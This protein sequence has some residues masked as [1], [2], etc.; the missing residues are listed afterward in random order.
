MTFQ[1]MQEVICDKDRIQKE[2]RKM[3]G[4]GVAT[5]NFNISRSRVVHVLFTGIH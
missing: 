4:V 2:E 5:E 1:Q 3:E